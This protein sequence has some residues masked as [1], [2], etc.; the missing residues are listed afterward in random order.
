MESPNKFIFLLLPIGFLYLCLSASGEL[1]SQRR[2]LFFFDKIEIKGEVDVFLNKGK[3]NR[4]TTVYA[5]SE[6][7]DSVITRVRGKTLYLEANNTFELARRLPFLKLNAKRRFPV[8]I[9]VSIDRL[10]EIRVLGSSNLTSTGL[11]SGNL[12]VF[13]ITSGK[14]HLENLDCPTLNLRHEGAGTVV[15]RGK[16]VSQLN[17][18]VLGDGS[19][20]AEEL[21]VEQA[22]L[23]HK[24]KG[25]AHLAPQTWLDARMHGPGNLLLH[26]KPE[27]MVVDQVG[28]GTVSDLLTDSLPLVDLNATNPQLNLKK[29]IR[30]KE[31]G[32]D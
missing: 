7:I 5:D 19:L 13:S 3:R 16:G 10:K 22:T 29:E 8:E 12:S 26:Q 14:L 18:Q 28:A 25:V 32:K 21:L 4:E 2:L 20:R 27:K 1:A 30:R 24:G 31:D 15:L 9:V 11:S 6:I 17:A 23:I